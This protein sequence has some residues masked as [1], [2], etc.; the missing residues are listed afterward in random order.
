MNQCSQPHQHDG[1]RVANR[2]PFLVTCQP[3]HSAFQCS[4][5]VNSPHQ[6]SSEVNTLVPSVTPHDIGSR[7][8]DLAIVFLGLSLDW[9]SNV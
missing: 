2:S 1:C 3:T 9:R 4:T 7:R 5:A 6:P 8:D